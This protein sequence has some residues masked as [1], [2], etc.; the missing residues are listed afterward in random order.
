[1]IVILGIFFFTLMLFVLHLFGFLLDKGS[2]P[3]GRS[4]TGRPK[5]G[6]HLLEVFS[7]RMTSRTCGDFDGR[8]QNEMLK[9]LTAFSA[10]VFKDWHR[11]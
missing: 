8:W 7:F 4:L 5:H 11:F 3:L 10:L 6:N 9:G 1:M 2:L